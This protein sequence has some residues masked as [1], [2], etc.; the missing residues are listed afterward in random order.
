MLP[1]LRSVLIR[2][3]LCFLPSENVLH[4]IKKNAWGSIKD[5]QGKR[6]TLITCAMDGW[7]GSSGY[8]PTKQATKRHEE[9][10][11]PTIRTA[12]N[13]TTLHEEKVKVECG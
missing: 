11:V 4:L 13:P 3:C 2:K 5:T 12:V 7:V 10:K 8:A 1:D 6:P 9:F